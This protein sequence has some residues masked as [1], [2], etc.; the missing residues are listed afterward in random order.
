MV[1]TSA[2]MES[3]WSATE[4]R[5]T[6][7]GG[8]RTGEH[9]RKPLVAVA[10]GDDMMGVRKGLGGSP[11]GARRGEEAW[12]CTRSRERN[13]VLAKQRKGKISKR[14]ALSP[15]IKLNLI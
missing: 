1:L 12:P 10:Q 2:T 8:A 9:R 5:P 15:I 7:G 11:S 3:F 14:V 4:Q 6:L 13:T